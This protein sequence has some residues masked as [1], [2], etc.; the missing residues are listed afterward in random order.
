M[1]MQGETEA[2]TVFA[3]EMKRLH[4]QAEICTH[5]EECKFDLLK[6]RILTGMTLS[7]IHI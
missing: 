2:F 5:C 4:A 7:L 1:R 6:T 3:N